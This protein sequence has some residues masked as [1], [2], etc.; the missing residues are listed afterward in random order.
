MTQQNPVFVFPLWLS[1]E[2]NGRTVRRMFEI[3]A[4]LKDVDIP[5]AARPRRI[6]IDPDGLLPGTIN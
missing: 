1:W 5:C 3:D 2:E 4:A 6:K